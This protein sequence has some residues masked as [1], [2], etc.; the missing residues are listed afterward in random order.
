MFNMDTL[1]I[2]L[3]ALGSLASVIGIAVAIIQTKKLRTLKLENKRKTWSQISTTKALM[4]DL[5]HK[6]STQALG[7]V[8]EQY[9][10]LLR[11]A[12][13]QEE[14][15]T[16]K[17]IKL[18]RKTGKLSSLWQERQALHLIQTCEISEKEVDQLEKEFMFWDENTDNS[19]PFDYHTERL[20]ILK[21]KK[22]K[23]ENSD[24]N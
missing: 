10:F 21:N 23:E 1:M 8:F 24:E 19:N 2:V 11:E 5:E 17:T 9:R 15:F 16:I 18:W 20:N 7:K 22:L 6:D 13:M 14:K 3:S 12:V 4:E